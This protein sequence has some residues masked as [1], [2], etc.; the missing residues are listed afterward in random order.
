MLGLGVRLTNWDRLGWKPMSQQ[1]QRMQ[2]GS[3][4]YEWSTE[5]IVDYVSPIERGIQQE[6]LAH[7]ARSAMAQL[8]TEKRE[9]ERRRKVS[10]ARKAAAAEQRTEQARLQADRQAEIDKANRQFRQLYLDCLR[11]GRLDERWNDVSYLEIILDWDRFYSI[12]RSAIAKRYAR[13]IRKPDRTVQ[14]VDEYGSVWTKTEVR[15]VDPNGPRKTKEADMP[16]GHRMTT[17][18]TIYPIYPREAVERPGRI[19]PTRMPDYDRSSPGV[20]AYALREQAIDEDT[21][22]LICV[23]FL[24][25][26]VN[27]YRQNNPLRK[28]RRQL[29]RALAARR[30]VEVVQGKR[31]FTG[32][33]YGR[34]YDR[35]SLESFQLWDTAK[36]DESTTSSQ[37]DEIDARELE[38]IWRARLWFRYSPV[39]ARKRL[40]GTAYAARLV[41]TLDGLLSGASWTELLGG[42]FYVYPDTGVRYRV[43]RRS[44]RTLAKDIRIVRK[45]CRADF[46]GTA[47]TIATPARPYVKRKTI[48]PG[49]HTFSVPIH[50][51]YVDSGRSGLMPRYRRVLRLQPKSRKVCHL[52]GSWYPLI[53]EGEPYEFEHYCTPVGGYGKETNYDIRGTK[54]FVRNVE[55]YVGSNRQSARQSC[56]GA[57]RLRRKQDAYR[58]A[59]RKRKSTSWVLTRSMMESLPE[60]YR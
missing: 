6:Q 55:V 11:E 20:S 41:W 56:Q 7:R 27:R 24:D 26:C 30:S 16:I 36:L 34:Q 44:E 42:G 1:G 25:L 33:K 59:D 35:D 50:F 45:V 22:E 48:Q 18:G 21:Q 14:R 38:E 60:R 15:F 32:N 9:R 2:V 43:P 54:P 19:S 39:S 13:G 3:N 5:D 51:D 58:V 10:A 17:K 28:S 31:R 52:P 46:D 29:W 40:G 12:C 8:D 53:L 37:F 47:Q 49:K 23:L 4:V 57:E